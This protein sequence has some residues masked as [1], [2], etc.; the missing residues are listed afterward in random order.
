MDQ[1]QRRVT[2]RRTRGERRLRLDRRENETGP[3]PSRL[4]GWPEQRMQFVMR[5]LFALLGILLFN[6]Y[7]APPL[8]ASLS[9]INAVFALYL[10]LNTLVLLHARHKPAAPT[11]YRFAMDVDIALASL[12]L[13]N[14]PHP[15]PP[16]LLVY[17]IIV[18]GNGMRY[19]IRLFGEA[20]GVS[21]VSAAITLAIRFHGAS[22]D[23]NVLLVTLCGAVILVYAY[24]LMRRLDAWQKQVEE[25]CRID[26]LTG[27]LNRRALFEAAEG[28]FRRVAHGGG[29]LAVLFADL[30]KFKN[31][32][33]VH[34]HA[35]GDR[36]LRAL[37]GILHDSVRGSDIAARHGGDEFVLI[38]PDTSLAE[39][40][41]IAHRI[42]ANVS[43]WAESQRLECNV[44]VGIGEAPTHGATLSEVLERVDLALYRAK[45]EEQWG[46]VCHADAAA[47]AGE[48]LA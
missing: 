1:Q 19:G 4:P 42:Q 22:P 8:H 10:A 24:L 47:A 5:Y 35:T 18:L 2:D 44:T 15:V 46:G 16:S 6:L 9:T 38:L 33:D 45:S 48:R 41:D 31:V 39:A 7:G 21:L 23:A 11:R 28:I 34:G 29:G 43:T 17:I 14:D 40:E 20:L 36:V 27:L 30:D 32:N 25:H 13:L 26:T 12:C 37:A 3:E